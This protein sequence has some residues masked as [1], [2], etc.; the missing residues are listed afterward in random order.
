MN[1]VFAMLLALGLVSCPMIAQE[2]EGRGRGGRETEEVKPDPELDAWVDTLITNLAKENPRIRASVEA[3]I[4]QVGRAALPKLEAAAKGDNEKVKAVATKL[5]E[6]IKA[7]PG[8][9]QRGE[10]GEGRGMG[11]MQRREPAE[12]AKE[13]S[14]DLS[15]SEEN[16]KKLEA[17]IKSHQTKQ[18]EMFRKFQEEGGGDREKMME[19]RTAMQE[20]L[21]KDLATYLTAEQVEKAMAKISPM[22]GGRRGQGGG[23]GGQ[24]PRRRPGQDQ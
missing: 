7:G 21:K 9:G 23:D 20:E 2:G 12:V 6:R 24:P 1:R 18:A 17:S 10:R 14:T 3:G 19:Q 4:I 8:Q 5:I 16:T 15:L 11:G 13:I 22:G